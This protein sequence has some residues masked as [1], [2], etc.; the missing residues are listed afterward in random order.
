MGVMMY[1]FVDLDDQEGF[2]RLGQGFGGVFHN[3][4]L[5]FSNEIVSGELVKVDAE[6]GLWLR[7]W[8]LMLSE[9]VV[10]R[11]LPAPEREEQRY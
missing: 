5:R 7:K 3:G 11:K 9:K 8:N 2:L 1:E 10:L 6:A 4:A